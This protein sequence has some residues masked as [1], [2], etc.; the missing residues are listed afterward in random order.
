MAAKRAGCHTRRYE[1][2]T[3]A[4]SKPILIELRARSLTLI[5]IY[6][7][8]GVYSHCKMSMAQPSAVA[9][10]HIPCHF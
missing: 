10:L 9:V 2:R 1:G 5:L 4:V 3:E 8:H 6:P 7:T